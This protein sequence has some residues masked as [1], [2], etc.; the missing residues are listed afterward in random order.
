MRMIYLL[1]LSDLVTAACCLM[2]PP[3]FIAFGNKKTV[4]LQVPRFPAADIQ[5]SPTPIT[6]GR[7][8]QLGVNISQHCYGVNTLFTSNIYLVFLNITALDALV[9]V[10]SLYSCLLDVGE[11][12]IKI[13]FCV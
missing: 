7:L 10:L 11:L 5:P 9:Y 13:I 2:S 8:L 6:R 12:V 3:L 1:W 4:G